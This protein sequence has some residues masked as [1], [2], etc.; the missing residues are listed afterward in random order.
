M[1]GGYRLYTE[2]GWMGRAAVVERAAL[3]EQAVHCIGLRDN[4]YEL[5]H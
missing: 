2:V 5:L 1:R 4:F 3:V